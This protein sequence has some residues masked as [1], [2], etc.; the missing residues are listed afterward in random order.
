MRNG[1]RAWRLDTRRIYRTAAA[2]TR[3]DP[4]WAA[5]R[6][7][8]RPSRRGG[9]ARASKNRTLRDKAAPRRRHGGRPETPPERSSAAA[10]V[11]RGTRV[12][13]T[14]LTHRTDFS[15]FHL[16]TTG[17]FF[18]FLFSFFPPHFYS[19]QRVSPNPHP[20]LVNLPPSVPENTRRI[21]YGYNFF[22]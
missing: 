1:N 18:F 7:R 3:R 8:R 10:A 4:S 12:I 2:V 11:S 14:A 17:R 15:V 13:V 16:K 5:R 20:T 21:R 9:R 6:R 19:F 22:F